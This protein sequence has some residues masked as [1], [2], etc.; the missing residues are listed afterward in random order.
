MGLMGTGIVG[1]IYMLVSRIDTFKQSPSVR[2]PHPGVLLRHTFPVQAMWARPWLT[3]MA[4]V[5]GLM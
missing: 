2:G 1:G 4:S 5:Y 3:L